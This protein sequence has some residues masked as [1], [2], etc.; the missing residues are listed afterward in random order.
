MCFLFICA[1]YVPCHFYHLNLITQMI[2]SRVR[3]TIHGVWIGNWIYSQLHFVTTS[4]YSTITDSHTLQLTT[5]Q[6]LFTAF[7]NHY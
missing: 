1:C 2:F 5:T 4:F 3:V 7:I 6:V